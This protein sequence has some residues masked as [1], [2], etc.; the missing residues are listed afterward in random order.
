MQNPKNWPPSKS[1]FP[2]FISFHINPMAQSLMLSDNSLEYLKK[3]EP[4]GCRDNFTREV[5]SKKGIEAYYS[6]CVTTTFRR[7][8]YLEPS[9]NPD[10][11]LIIGP[12]DRLKPE[13]NKTSFFHLKLRQL[14][15]LTLEIELMFRGSW[16]LCGLQHSQQCSG[17]C[18]TWA[19]LA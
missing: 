16:L 14:E 9:D 4:I 15:R 18:I 8:N 11:I 10:G 13:I 6:S 2:L 7:E 17:E 1:I 5:L 3:Y 12:F 19:I